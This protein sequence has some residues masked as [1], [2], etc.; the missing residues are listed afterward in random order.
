MGPFSARPAGA[1]TIQIV[2]LSRELV[3]DVTSIHLDAFPDYM[4]SLLGPRYVNALMEWFRFGDRRVALVAI[5]AHRTPVGYVIGA[6]SGYSRSLTRDLLWVAGRSLLLRPW[7][8]LRGEFR[9]TALDRL[10][11]M[12]LGSSSHSVSPALP[13]P[14]MALVG[15]AV[16][17]EA[18]GRDVGRLL[19]QSFEA[20]ALKLG[21]KSLLLSVYSDNVPARRLYERY[22]WKLHSSHGRSLLYSKIPEAQ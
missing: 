16:S 8:A 7:A 14:T 17:R 1:A 22:R 19:L 9:D 12:L 18:R 10:R 3:P 5:D 20:A 2:G 6:P 13:P 11:F 21:M 15:I 4:S